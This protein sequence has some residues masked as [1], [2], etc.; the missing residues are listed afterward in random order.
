MSEVGRI[1]RRSGSLARV[2]GRLA[3][4]IR[5]AGDRLFRDEDARARQRGWQITASRGGL[6]RTYRDPRFGSLRS[7]PACR[8]TGNGQD[9]QACDHCRGMG[10]TTAVPPLAPEAGRGR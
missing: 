8:G 3:L 7:C 10:R 1:P 5:A 9:D 2:T 4:A 6:A